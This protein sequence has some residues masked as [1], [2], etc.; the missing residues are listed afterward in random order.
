MEFKVTKGKP[1]ESDYSIIRRLILEGYNQ[2]IGDPEGINWEIDE[3]FP[4]ELQIDD[5]TP[6]YLELAPKRR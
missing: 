1:T 4:K 6:E 3:R 2:G 5:F